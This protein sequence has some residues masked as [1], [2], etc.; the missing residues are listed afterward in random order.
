MRAV[1]S[2]KKLYK[3]V[4]YSQ[5]RYIDSFA[6]GFGEVQHKVSHIVVLMTDQLR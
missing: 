2:D 1:T 3:R 4:T 6:V 5:T